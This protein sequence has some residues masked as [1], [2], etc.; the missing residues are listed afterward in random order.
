M[1][2]QRHKN[3]ARLATSIEASLAMDVKERERLDHLQA[4]HE[5]F[6]QAFESKGGLG[7]MKLGTL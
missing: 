1:S 5:L 6:L 2:V 7:D 3:S 4:D